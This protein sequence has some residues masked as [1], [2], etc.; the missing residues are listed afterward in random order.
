MSNIPKRSK[1]KNCKTN[2]FDPDEQLTPRQACA[3]AAER[4]VHLNT[5]ILMLLRRDGKGPQ[6]LKI[7]G[8]W[9][10]YTRRYLDP[11][12]KTRL[13]RVIRPARQM[14]ERR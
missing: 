11:F 3:Y 2:G 9:I 4:D 8:R 7:N 6:Y 14:K 12:I 1:A 5:N 13:P 10:R